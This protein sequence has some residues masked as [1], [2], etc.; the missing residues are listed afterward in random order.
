MVIFKFFERKTIFINDES[1]FKTIRYFL[2]PVRNSDGHKT[3]GEVCNEV[4]IDGK[5]I[6]DYDRR[7]CEFRYNKFH[8]YVRG[9][10]NSYYEYEY[11]SIEYLAETLECELS[12][13]DLKK[14]II[15][16]LMSKNI[17]RACWSVDNQWINVKTTCFDT[18]LEKGFIGK[19]IIGYN[20]HWQAKQGGCDE[21]NCDLVQCNDRF[22]LI[23]PVIIT[24]RSKQYFFKFVTLGY[25]TM[26]KMRVP[27][28]TKKNQILKLFLDTMG[29]NEYMMMDFDLYYI[30]QCTNMGTELGYNNSIEKT[31]KINNENDFVVDF[32]EQNRRIIEPMFINR[33]MY[34]IF[35][36]ISLNQIDQLLGQ[37][38]GMGLRVPKDLVNLIYRYTGFESESFDDK[39]FWAD[40]NFI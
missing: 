40:K 23:E 1:K 31:I 2:A 21:T 8:Q 25:S 5:L 18:I 19:K 29:T 6:T 38:L 11:V 7:L 12:D 14:P 9:F 13:Q 20:W 32:A 15:D 33:S 10:Q 24:T 17:K 27:V 35:G 36:K 39:N 26:F 30:N 4:Y 34:V 37:G 3:I 16:Y 22:N 28:I